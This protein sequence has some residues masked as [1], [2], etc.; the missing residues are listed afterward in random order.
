MI[1]TLPAEKPFVSFVII[2]YNSEEYILDALN[3]IR[4][5]KYQ[6]IEII[7]ADDAS[8]DS[9]VSLAEKWIKSNS[10]KFCGCSIARS[11][12]NAGISANCNRG[13]KY[14]TGE[15]VKFLAADDILKANC[16]NVFMDAYTKHHEADVIH[17]NA[18]IMVDDKIV[19]IA[20]PDRCFIDC[21]NNKKQ[22]RMMLGNNYILAPTVFLKRQSVLEV[23]CFDERFEMMEDY[24]LWLKML[25]AG[26]LFVYVDNETVIYRKNP[27]SLTGI[28]MTPSRLR[29]IKSYDKFTKKVIL[30]SLLKTGQLLKFFKRT[31]NIIIKSKAGI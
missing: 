13:L 20:R 17:S 12:I 14:C 8:K 23:G 21:N 15:W 3:S 28:K 25:K 30:P 24:P 1:H 4:D 10:S 9:T 2:S 26:K 18:D 22:Y 27:V 7:V 5:Q 31:Y 11:E 29:Y 6:Q 16:L 19:D